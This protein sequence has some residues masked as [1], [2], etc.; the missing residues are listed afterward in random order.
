LLD[1][2]NA[3]YREGRFRDAVNAYRAA[4]GVDTGGQFSD[5][6][7]Y[8]YGASLLK[9]GEES[10]ALSEFQAVVAGSPGSPHFAASAMET[11]SLF[12]EK[13]NY[14]QARRTLY[15]LLAARD[16]LSAGDKDYV[17]RASFLVG[18]CL[19]SEAGAR[20][21]AQSATLPVAR[22]GPADHEG[23]GVGASGAGE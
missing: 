18:T 2:A 13:K 1:A 16:R 22:F 10:S 5:E 7:H 23:R 6:A 12:M 19:E 9:I 8:R 4:A 14:A 15:L 20:E 3:D 21:A 11:A 17:E